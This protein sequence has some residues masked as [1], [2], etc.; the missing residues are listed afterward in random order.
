MAQQAASSGTSNDAR[1]GPLRAARSRRLGLGVG[2]GGVL[3]HRDHLPAGLHPGPGLLL[4]GQPDDRPR[5]PRLEPDQPLP[6]VERVAAV[7]AARR[8]GDPVGGR[9]AGDLAA[10]SRGPTAPS[11][12]PARRCCSSAAATARSRPTRCSSR[13]RRDRAT[14][15]SGGTGPSCPRLAPTAP[16]RSRAA[17]SSTPAASGPTA[18]RPT[19]MYIISTTG[20]ER[21]SSASGRRP[22]TPVSTSTCRSRSPGRCSCRSPTG[23]CSSAGRPTGRRR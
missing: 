18:S 9:A 20:H 15:T 23:C 22:R 8:G 6:A 7:P 2:Q 19:T 16:R 14:S 3:V 13:R 11:S 21:R 10:R 5:H 17:A 4:H 12:S 1:P